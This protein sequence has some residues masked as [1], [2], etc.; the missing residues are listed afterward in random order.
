MLKLKKD[1]RKE[2]MNNTA[3]RI[4]YQGHG[5]LRITTAEGKVIYIDPYAGGGYEPAADLILI[6]HGHSDHTNTAKIRAHNPGCRV[7]SW[8][9]ALEGGK[10]NTFDLGFVTVQAVEAGY[11]RNHNVKDCVGYILTLPGSVTVYASGDT[12][13]TEQMPLLARNNIDYA[14]FCCDGIYNMDLDEASQ[15]AAL[16]GA[17]HS[18]PYHMAPGMLFDR[19]RA[20]KFNAPGRLIIAD[21]EKFELI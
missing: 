12:S 5:S 10:H 2:K 14:F 21:G 15:C 18:I 1:K 9:E 17:K 3:N 4:L 6:T 8:K 16:V 20:E 7:I 19:A 11:N 13:K